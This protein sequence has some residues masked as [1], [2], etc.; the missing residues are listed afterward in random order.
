MLWNF[1]YENQNFSAE[2]N[3][4]ILSFGEARDVLG[5]MIFDSKIVIIP[6]W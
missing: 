6:S 1:S 3:W 5:H 4:F 2:Y